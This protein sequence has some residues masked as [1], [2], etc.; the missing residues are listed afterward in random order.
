MSSV[1]IAVAA[2]PEGMPAVV[3]VIMAMGVQ[4]MSKAH[5]IVRRRTRWKR[6]AHAAYLFG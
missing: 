3:T 1:A 6:W 4:K 5:A 2:I